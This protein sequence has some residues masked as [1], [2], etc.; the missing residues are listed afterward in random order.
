MSFDGYADSVYLSWLVLLHGSHDVCF[1]FFHDCLT[2]VS[3]VRFALGH[4]LVLLPFLYS[5]LDR[6]VSTWGHPTPSPLRQPN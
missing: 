2:H 5:S 1:C 6:G 3:L 4:V